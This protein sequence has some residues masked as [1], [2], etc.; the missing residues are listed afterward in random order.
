MKRDFELVRKILLEIE[1]LTEPELIDKDSKFIAGYEPEQVNYHLLLLLDANLI[2]AINE[3]PDDKH[4]FWKIERLTWE[5]HDFL[6]A[7]RNTTIWEKAKAQLGQ[8]LATLPITVLKA[9]LLDL[10]MRQLGLTP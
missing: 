8:Q 6:D 3:N 4:F 7:A 5:G 1:G 9:Y 10:T 2:S